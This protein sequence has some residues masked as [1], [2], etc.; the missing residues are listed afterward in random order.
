MLI[1]LCP[2]YSVIQS[3][4]CNLNSISANLVSFVG[5]KFILRNVTANISESIK[6]IHTDLYIHTPIPT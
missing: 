5:N 3:T 1:K 6:F 4:L 2:T